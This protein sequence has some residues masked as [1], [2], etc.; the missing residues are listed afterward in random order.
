MRPIGVVRLK[1]VNSSKKTRRSWYH[2]IDTKYVHILVK[3]ERRLPIQFNG[4]FLRIEIDN[5]RLNLKRQPMSNDRIVVGARRRW[6]GCCSC[7]KRLDGWNLTLYQLDEQDSVH[8]I[9]K[10]TSSSSNDV[11]VSSISS[12]L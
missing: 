11:L 5:L 7:T 4:L 8:T 6:T 1:K 12:V 10:G 3:F 2:A 9:E